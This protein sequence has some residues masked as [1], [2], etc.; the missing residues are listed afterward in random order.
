MKKPAF[1]LLRQLVVACVL[2]AAVPLACSSSGI[3]GGDCRSGLTECS[4]KC[5]DL[6]SDPANCGSCGN[7][8][9]EGVACVNGTCEGSWT[10][11]TCD[12]VHGTV[13]CC[14]Q[15]TIP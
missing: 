7:A 12:D 13:G 14:W 11:M 9:A 2:A 3:V 10:P 15:R 4:G 6:S 8:C 1:K 5:L